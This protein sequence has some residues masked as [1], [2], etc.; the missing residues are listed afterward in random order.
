MSE[1]VGRYRSEDAERQEAALLFP[2]EG[3]IFE[4]TPFE[5]FYWAGEALNRYSPT[6]ASISSAVISWRLVWPQARCGPRLSRR[7][8]L[9]LGGLRCASYSHEARDS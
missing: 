9:R 1:D 5:Y 8:A 3:T 7:R 6:P 4:S 2:R